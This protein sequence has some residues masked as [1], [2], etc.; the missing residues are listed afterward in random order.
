MT[1]AV[2]STTA[3][4]K[5]NYVAISTMGSPLPPLQGVELRVLV[6]SGLPDLCSC[7]TPIVPER[8]GGESPSRI[9]STAPSRST[10]PSSEIIAA[11]PVAAVV[12]AFASLPFGVGGENP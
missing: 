8:R 7:A 6:E 11:P 5:N 12:L 9:S 2:A 3:H 1:L 10:H 4:L